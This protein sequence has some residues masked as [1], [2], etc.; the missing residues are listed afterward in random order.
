MKSR[1]G[2]RV[3][4]WLVRVLIVLGVLGALFINPTPSSNQ[5]DVDTAIIRTYDAEFTITR[6]GDL[7][8]VENLMV[9]MP[10]GKHGIYRIFDTADP[11]RPNVEHPVEVISVKR[12]GQAESFLPLES[13]KGTETIRIGL[14]N[15]VLEPGIHQYTI[16]S[17]TSNVFEPGDDPNT[18]LWWWDVVGSGWSMRID[19]AHVVAKLPTAPKSSRCVIGKDTPCEVSVLDRQMIINTGELAPFEP[20][21][22]KLGFP[23]A[24]LPAPIAPSGTSPWTIV[25]SVLTALAGAGVAFLLVRQTKEPAVGLPA[26]FEPPEGIYPA[27]GAKVI[28]EV[29]SPYA[30]QA[31][32]FDLAE[33]GLLSL[34]GDK[35][36]WDITVIAEPSQTTMTAAEA[37]VLAKLDLN[38]KGSQFHLRK[39]KTAG[40]KVSQAQSA[41]K[42]Q[43]TVDARPYLSFSVVGLLAT[44]GAWVALGLTGFQI[45]V[46]FGGD[47]LWPLLAGTAA[48]AFVSAGVLFDRAAWS[49][50]NPAG[51]EMWSRVGGFARFLTT[52]SAETRF[53][54]AQ[55]MDLYPRYLP[56][57]IVFG[58]ADKWAQRYRDQGI[59][60]PTVP[61]LIWS[62]SSSGFSMTSM[63]DSFNSSIT[64]AASAYAAS[65]AASSGGGGGGFS[66]GSGG[67]GGGGGSW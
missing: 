8:L 60:P 47:V 10:S 11:R 63:S 21:T 16:E 33:R 62:G 20:V 17:R 14:P 1:A 56:W 29:N 58:S 59:E 46:A 36:G 53:D 35:S 50:R 27:L 61:W 54:F 7:S 41:L 66:G 42:S 2:L 31:T 43:V 28:D 9:E 3:V 40:E 57:A 25:F 32:L 52:D 45:F 22:V 65:Q 67:G 18:T 4:A 15:V 5:G 19:S 30:L 37:E 6:S 44:A 39:D 38:F 13:A 55:K 64:G 26:T 24:A 34:E 49:T 12:D 23:A 48:F 51:R